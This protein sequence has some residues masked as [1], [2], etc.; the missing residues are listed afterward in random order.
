MAE[1]YIFVRMRR[2]DFEKIVKEKKLPMEQDLKEITG[3][4]IHIKNIQLF[5]IAANST[6]DLGEDY[7]HKIIRA[8]KLKRSNLNL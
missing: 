8:I 6:W 5:R 3:K 4:P 7:Q 1:R 2:E